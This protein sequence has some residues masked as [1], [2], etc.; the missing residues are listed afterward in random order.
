MYD[1]AFCTA[2]DDLAVR[3]LWD[4]AFPEEPEFNDWFFANEYKCKYCLALKQDNK[5][6]AMAQLLPYYIEGVGEVS[7]VYGAATHPDYRR[8]GLMRELLKSAEELDKGLGRVASVLIPA[9]EGLFEFYSH[10]GYKTAFYVQKGELA[11]PVP[12][13]G[14][15]LRKADDSDIK[16]MNELYLKQKGSAIV[17]DFDYWHRQLKMFAS[18]GGEV[19]ILEHNCTCEGYAFITDGMAQEAFGNIEVLLSLA[20][21]KK[22]ITYSAEGA[23]TPIGMLL[24]YHD[25]M[26]SKMYMNMMFN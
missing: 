15:K 14:Y 9:N 25:N 2:E 23:N 1:I 17:R 10:L 16:A 8:R 3:A 5:I 21:V 18:L 4:T 12:T 6:L 22:Y 11:K 13:V 24:P 19:C 20:G 26:P 7:Y